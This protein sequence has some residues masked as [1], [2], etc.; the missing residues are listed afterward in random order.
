MV[1]NKHSVNLFWDTRRLT[2]AREDHL[3]CFLAAALEVDDPFRS[4][5]E[6]EVFA[7]LATGGIVPRIVDIQTQ[8][9]FAEHHSRPDMMLVLDDG[10]RVACEHKIDAAETRYVTTD[11]ITEKQ[12]EKYLTRLNDISAVVYFRPALTTLRDV[13]CGHPRYLHPVHAPHFLWRDLYRPLTAGTSELSGWLRQGFEKLGFTPP[14]PHIGELWPDTDAQVRQNESNFAKL[15]DST[16]AHVSALWKVGRGS[17]CELYLRPKN[18]G[19]VSRVQITPGAQAGTLLRIRAEMDDSM[20]DD[21][22]RRW[23]AAST[24]LPVLMELVPGRLPNRRAI[25]DLLASLNLVVGNDADPQKQEARLKA[26][27]A[28]VVDE[29]DRAIATVRRTK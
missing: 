25:I 11:G 15:W 13:V 9:A 26:Q 19:P 3:T 1:V 2:Q 12:L 29:V 6:S 14:L 20:I 23:H 27:V 16:I 8:V 21:L 22:T 5:Y 7:P 4:A 17:R 24:Q 10:R 18:P 28:P